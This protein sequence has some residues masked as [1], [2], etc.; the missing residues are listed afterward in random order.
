MQILDTYAAFCSVS[1]AELE[2]IRSFLSTEVANKLAVS[3]ILSTL[4]Y[5]KSLLAGI[6][7]KKLNKLQRIQNHAARLVLRKFRHASATALLRTVHWLPVKARIH[8]KIA[9]LCFQC[10]Y[11]NSTPPYISDL[12][13]HT[14]HPYPYASLLIPLGK[15]LSLLSGT[16]YRYPSEKLSV[17]EC[18]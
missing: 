16:H 1:W 7:D 11:Q 2:K 9:C 8:Y 18:I 6:P 5:R 17:Y 4:D 3:L 10:V 14:P 15:D 13:T 12:L